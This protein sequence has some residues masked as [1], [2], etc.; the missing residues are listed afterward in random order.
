[1][2]LP[3]ADVLDR[4]DHARRGRQPGRGERRH[5][6]VAVRAGDDGDGNGLRG[7]KEGRARLRADRRAVP[8]LGAVADDPLRQHRLDRGVVGPEPG[9]HDLGVGEPRELLVV[10]I[11]GERLPLLGEEVAED[12]EEQRLRQSRLGALPGELVGPLQQALDAEED[13]KQ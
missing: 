4:D 7:V 10:H 13:D 9:A 11:L 12:R 1:V 8:D 5:D 2:G 6:L 3:G